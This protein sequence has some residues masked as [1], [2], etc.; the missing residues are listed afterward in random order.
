M[1]Q[2]TGAPPIYHLTNVYIYIYIDAFSSKYNVYI[3]R[4]QYSGSSKLLDYIKDDLAT[5]IDASASTLA[6]KIETQSVAQKAL[7]TKV[8]GVDKV[9]AKAAEGA[10]AQADTLAA[11]VAEKNAAL[12]ELVSKELKTAADVSILL[13]LQ[14]NFKDARARIEV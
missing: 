7:A 2:V 1:L 9:I 13:C 12:K 6:A 3:V 5:K 11:E 8:D 4:R 10:K 14:G